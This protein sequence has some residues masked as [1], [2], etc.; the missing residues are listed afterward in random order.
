M[1]DLALLI[2]IVAIVMIAAI[3]I[4]R[5][6]L[7]SKAGNADAALEQENRRLREE[8]NETRKRLRVLERIVTDRGADTAAQIEALRD[9]DR[10]S[11]DESNG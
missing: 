6:E 4:K 1:I 9:R 8:M 7:Q 11:E 3:I 5:M 2:P 10:I